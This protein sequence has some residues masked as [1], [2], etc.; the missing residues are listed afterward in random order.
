MRTPVFGI[1]V[2]V[3][4]H[5]LAEP[6]KGTGIAMVCTFGDITD[7]VWWR[8]WAAHPAGD[9]TRRPVAG[10][11]PTE[12]DRAQAAWPLP[13]AGQATPAA[14]RQQAAELLREDGSL[15]GE[16]EPVTHR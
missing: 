15:T 11:P 14:A 3:V 1:D 12:I 10:R 5:R 2:P 9:R 4:A 8:D 13:A 7:I 6:D 16:P